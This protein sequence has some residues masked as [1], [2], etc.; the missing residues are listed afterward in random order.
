[1]YHGYEQKSEEQVNELKDKKEMEEV[2]RK[3]RREEQEANVQKKTTIKEAKEERK[4][5]RKL[6]R[7]ASA[8]NAL[9]AEAGLPI[10]E[11]D[12]ESID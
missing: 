8:L 11:K 6:E 9:K 1:M 5:Q 4:K 7:D 3:R 2:T 12:E 10:V